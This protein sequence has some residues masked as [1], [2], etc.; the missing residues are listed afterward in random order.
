MGLKPLFIELL[1]MNQPG[2]DTERSNSG[3]KPD[4][5]GISGS[6]SVL[7]YDV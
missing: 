7:T 2:A 5:V 1:A 4:F 6:N 3:S